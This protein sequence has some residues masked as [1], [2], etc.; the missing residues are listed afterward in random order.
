MTRLSAD[1]YLQ[2]RLGDQI[3]WYDRK[4]QQNQAWH[5]RLRL[6]EVVA[7]GAIP[8]MAGYAPDGPGWLPLAM[9]AAGA[10]VAVIAAVL[11]LF[12]FEQK[13][14]EYRTTCE[15][16]KKEKYLY[17]TGTEPFDGSD[18]K[19]FRTLVQRTEALISRENTR[20]AEYAVGAGEE[21]ASGEAH[22]RGPAG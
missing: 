2:S 1:D 22:A 16:L 18:E 15:S 13:W 17:L 21:K 10:L 9:G 3:A 12:Q 11:G 6:A 5:N 19:S 7:A 4:S 20:W 8:F 14:I